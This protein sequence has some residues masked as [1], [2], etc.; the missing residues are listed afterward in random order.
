[1]KI[2]AAAQGFINFVTNGLGYFVGAFVSGSVVDNWKLAGGAGHD[3]HSIWMVPAVM[4]LVVLITFAVLFRPAP[5]AGAAA[6]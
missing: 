3:W 6:A 5:R 2:R 4:A 1:V